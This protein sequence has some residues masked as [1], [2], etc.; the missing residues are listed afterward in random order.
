MRERSPLPQFLINCPELQQGLELY[1]Q[2]FMELS[3][4]RGVGF[5]EGPIPWTAMMQWAVHNSLSDDQTDTLVYIMHEMDGAY[6]RHMAAKRKT[7]T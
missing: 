3:T 4:C 5:G 7:Q 2:A 6:L 1:F